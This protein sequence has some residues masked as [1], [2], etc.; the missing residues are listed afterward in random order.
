MSLLF[1]MF[2]PDGGHLAWWQE[3][4]RVPLIFAAGLALIRVSGLRTFSRYSAL[5]TVVTIL[6][7]SNLSRALTGNAPVLGT[8]VAS[9]ALVTLHRLLAQGA[10]HSPAMARLLKGASKP[11][12]EHGVSVARAMRAEAISEG[13][14]QEA[15]RLRGLS[16][17]SASHHAILERNGQISIFTRE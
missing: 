4:L 13:D 6:I 11:L 17:L 7:G 3:T 16:E 8:L 10:L 2:G 5:D 1:L 9:L 15:M 12:V 14:L